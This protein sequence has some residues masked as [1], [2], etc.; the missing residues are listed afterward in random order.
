MN[1]LEK[2]KQ[3]IDDIFEVFNFKDMRIAEL[4]GNRDSL[5][6]ENEKLVSEKAALLQSNTERG[7]LIEKLN[8]ELL[9]LG[10][11]LEMMQCA[12]NCVCNQ[13]EETEE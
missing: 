11:E 9:E 12:N 5:L 13:V 4:K 10:K 3:A 2:L 8:S 1:E 7:E 6:S